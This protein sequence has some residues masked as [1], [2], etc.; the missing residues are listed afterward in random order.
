MQTVGILVFDDVEELDFV[1]PLEVFG[2]AARFGADCRPLILAEAAKAVRARY[3]LNVV[4]DCTLTNAP[5]L[6]VLI[7]PGG[8]GART[9]ARQNL[10]IL[11]FIR[12]QR[13][14]VASICTGA[15]IL[16]EA[17]LLN[18]LEATTHHTAFDELQQYRDIRL[19]RGDRYVIGERIATSAGVT[20]GLDLSL[21]LVAKWWGV[22]ITEKI[23][24]N[25]EWQRSTAEEGTSVK[26]ADDKATPRIFDLSAD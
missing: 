8:L 24:A 16:A 4:P 22:E 7:V 17:G 12:A 15:L 2:M 23:A 13:G 26:A 9:H 3:G 21:A 14:L 11:N 10:A 18:G 20:A 5:D 1:G 6:F 25:L 19:R